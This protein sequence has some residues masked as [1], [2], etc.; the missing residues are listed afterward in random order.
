M[1]GLP[2]S[3]LDYSFKNLFI[4]LTNKKAI[5]WIS[6]IGFIVYDTCFLMDLFGMVMKFKY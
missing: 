1:Q 2:E 4:P 5:I 3:D 6:I